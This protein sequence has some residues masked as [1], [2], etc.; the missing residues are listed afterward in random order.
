MG[1]LDLIEQHDRVR[2][3]AHRLGE[4]TALV[5]ANVAGRGADQTGHGEFLHI[6]RHI[7]PDHTALIVKQSFRK[8]LGKLGLAHAGRS[9]KQERTDRAVGIGNARAGAQNGFRHLIHGFILPDHPFMQNLRQIQQLLPFAFHQLADRNSR[10]LG[11]DA[12]DFFLRHR[13]AHKRMRTVC[14]RFLRRRQFLFQLRQ[15]RIPQFCGFLILIIPL[16]SFHLA[17][18]AL[19]LRLALLDGVDAVFLVFPFGFQLSELLLER[20]KLLP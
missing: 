3:S 14:R 19:D 18:D 7:N 1:F 20:G 12:G 17:L 16:C 6:L 9:Q 11:D 2:F 15:R 13:I 4:L 8:R 5:I 10:P